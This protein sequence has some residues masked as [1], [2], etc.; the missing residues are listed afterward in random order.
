M[1]IKGCIV[2]DIL[3]S[4]YEFGTSVDFDYKTVNLYDRNMTFTDDTIMALAVKKAV[5]NN[6]EQATLMIGPYGKGKL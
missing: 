3:G 5:L 2:G 4:V 1:A 6:K